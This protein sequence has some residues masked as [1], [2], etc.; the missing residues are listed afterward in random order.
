MFLPVPGKQQGCAWGTLEKKQVGEWKLEQRCGL[1][2]ESPQKRFHGGDESAS[3]NS[4]VMDVFILKT[5]LPFNAAIARL[6][7]EKRAG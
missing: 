7:Q 1:W 2:T 4:F 6:E 3:T 5:K